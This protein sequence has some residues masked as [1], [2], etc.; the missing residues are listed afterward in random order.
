MMNRNEKLEIA[1]RLRHSTEMEMSRDDL[2]Q[3]LDAELT[4]PETEMDAEL[5]AQILELLEDTPS[6]I[7]QHTSWQ[8]LEK[9]L[10]FKR[11]Q[12]AVT[13][14]ARIAAAVVFVVAMLFATYGTAHALNWEFL[15]RLMKP[16]AETFMVY[17]G[18]APTPTPAPKLDEVYSDINLQFTQQEFSTLADCPDKL[19]GYPVKPVWMPERFT[20]LFGN[21]YTD[22]QVTAIT[23][24][25]KSEG[26]SCILD[27]A[28]F[29]D[30]KDASSYHY[31]QLPEDNVSMYMAGCQVAFYNNTDNMTLAA[32]W[33]SENTNYVI[34]GAISKEEIILII[35]SM[36]K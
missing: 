17:T 22:C 5:V 23:H 31:E 28:K 14:L 35:E 21:M 24:V 12:P 33:L 13:G 25:F 15:L 27:I 1:K 8:K 6:P 18:S 32:S 19:D 2:E 10:S 4:K 16:F 30:S 7:Q 9:R 36:M 20:Y 11:W 34:T 3:M 29:H 26:G